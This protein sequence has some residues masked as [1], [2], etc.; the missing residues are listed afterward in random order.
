MSERVRA[1]LLGALGAE[2]TSTSDLYDRIGYPALM[3]AGLIDYREF[4]KRLAE[5]EG[6]G[7]AQSTKGDDETGTLWRLPDPPADGGSAPEGA[8]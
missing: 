5:L 4:R 1:T 2:P 6:D 7:L 8:G 3:R